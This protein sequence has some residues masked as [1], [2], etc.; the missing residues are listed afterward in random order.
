M[1]SDHLPHFPETVQQLQ[2]WPSARNHMSPILQSAETN[3]DT[4]AA[5]ITTF[6]VSEGFLALFPPGN[7][8]AYPFVLQCFS[9]PVRVM[10]AIPEQPINIWNAVQQRPCTDVVADLPGGHERVR[11]AAGSLVFIPPLVRPL[12]AASVSRKRSGMLTDRLSNRESPGL[13]EINGS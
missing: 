12:S 9:E 1:Q 8:G 5:F 2:E 11:R 6:V 4:V 3:L 7:T 10:A 13:R